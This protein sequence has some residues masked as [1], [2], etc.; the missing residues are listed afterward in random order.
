MQC[1]CHKFNTF[2]QDC[3]PFIRY[4]YLYTLPKISCWLTNIAHHLIGF[5]TNTYS[6]ILIWKINIA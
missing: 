1:S 3:I 2:P 5:C 6:T 4:L